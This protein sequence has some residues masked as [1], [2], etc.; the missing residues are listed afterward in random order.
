MSAW[1]RSSAAVKARLLRRRRGH[2]RQ[3]GV[4]HEA[5]LVLDHLR[6][7]LHLELEPRGGA[8][9]P[10]HRGAR[11]GAVHAVA[12]VVAVGAGAAQDARHVLGPH[13]DDRGAPHLRR[14]PRDERHLGEARQHDEPEE[15]LAVE[16][17]VRRRIERGAVAVAEAQ[18]ILAELALEALRALVEVAA[19]REKPLL[20]PAPEA[21]RPSQR[22]AQ[23][24]EL[25]QVRL[26]EAEGEVEP[27]DEAPLRPARLPVQPP[28]ELLA[29]VAPPGRILE[30]T[31]HLDELGLALGALDL[32]GDDLVSGPLDAAPRQPEHGAALGQRDL[33][34]GRAPPYRRAT[35]TPVA[36]ARHRPSC[37]RRGFRSLGPTEI[38]ARVTRS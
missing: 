33:G 2:R 13:L 37:L 20:E 29:H 35:A 14:I 19:R 30:R 25:P 6:R 32:G 18:P 23:Q 10:Q 3:H 24:A 5:L 12:R 16:A 1:T 27:D 34:R 28:C 11:A 4:E 36:L 22:L 26:G 17:G 9:D 15:R 31:P 7:Q 38:A 8:Q 21:R